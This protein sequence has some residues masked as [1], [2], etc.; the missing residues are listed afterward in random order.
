MEVIRSIPWTLYILSVEHAKKKK[1]IILSN[2]GNIETSLT[3]PE[4]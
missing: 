3:T 1:E 4:P 2:I